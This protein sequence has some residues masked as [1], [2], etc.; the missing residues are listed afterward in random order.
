METRQGW[1]I[2]R[3]KTM[4][5]KATSLSSVIQKTERI[6]YQNYLLKIS[7]AWQFLNIRFSIFM[8]EARCLA[9]KLFTHSYDY[10]LL[11]FV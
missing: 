10:A 8:A 6:V 11:R 2:N 5:P 3:L 7:A 1:K 4:S 9:Q